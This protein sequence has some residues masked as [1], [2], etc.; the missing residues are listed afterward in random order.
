MKKIIVSSIMIAL[1]AAGSLLKA[2]N[3]EEY[4]GLPG[5]NLNLYAVMQ[6]FQQSQ[7]L[8]EFERKLNDPD[9][10]INNLDLNG[11]NMVDYI[12]VFDDVDGN[13]HN[14]VLQVAVNRRENQDIA[15]FTVQRFNNGQVMVQL[16]GD[17]ALYG[18]NY[19][20]EPVQETVNPGYSGNNRYASVSISF[21]PVVRFIY[22]PT[23][24]VWHSNWHWG[25]YPQ[26]WRPW[27]P[28]S[29]HYYYGYHYNWNPYYYGHYHQADHHYY[30]RWD[31]YYYHGRRSYSNEVDHNIKHGTYKATYSH[32]EQKRQGEQLYAT[33][34]PDRRGNSNPG[35][36]RKS[37]NSVNGRSNDKPRSFSNS[38]YSRRTEG[39]VSNKSVPVNNPSVN[40]TNTNN[41]EIRSNKSQGNGGYNSS[42]RNIKTSEKAVNQP[43]GN[44]RSVNQSQGNQTSRQ[45]SSGSQSNNDQKQSG[46]EVRRQSSHPQQNASKSESNSKSRSESS[47]SKDSKSKD[48]E[49][50]DSHRR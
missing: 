26:Y 3:R 17:E 16:T 27:H 32:P 25:Y 40:R 44:R 38:E 42:D 29:W 30:T 28:L 12:K 21:W 39:T 47:K 45:I 7:T 4:L 9:Q 46:G 10:N 18:R 33:K 50:S 48:S 24:T 31:D 5:D 11:D 19:I 43:Q 14:I 35:E 8:E 23:Y 20:I 36:S 34:Y 2:Q 15:V 37:D 13:V 41:K 1:F 49:A 6:L 22:L